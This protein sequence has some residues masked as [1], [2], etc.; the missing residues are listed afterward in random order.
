MKKTLC[1]VFTVLFPI[2][3]L[4][5]S[6]NAE[7]EVEYNVYSDPVNKFYL[8][9]PAGWLPGDN[10]TDIVVYIIVETPQND[11][12]NSLNVQKI[13]VSF[14]GEPQPK[15]AI[16]MLSQ[17]ILNDLS[18]APGFAIGR[19]DYLTT[20]AGNARM[21]DVKYSYNG[22]TLRQ[23]QII[24]YHKDALY[25]IAYTADFDTFNTD[26]FNTAINSFNF[27]E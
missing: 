22:K 6:A 3:G 17:Q 15:E 4:I 26:I 16:D 1:I 19:D 23:A 11:P 14:P 20:P 18:S 2:F 24:F 12:V 10:K 7:K 21:F 25:M 27:T 8:K 9:A 13:P 5:Q